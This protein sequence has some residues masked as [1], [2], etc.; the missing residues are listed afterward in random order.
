MRAIVKVP[1]GK[2][3]SVVALLRPS[4]GYRRYGERQILRR[5]GQMGSNKRLRCFFPCPGPRWGLI[6]APQFGIKPF[7][8]FGR[9]QADMIIGV[10]GFFASGKDTVADFL[11]SQYGFGHLSLSDMIRDRL[12][13]A[14]DPITIERLTEM[15]NRIRREEGPGALGR[16]ALSRMRPERRYVV[17]S[18]RHPDEL[19]TLRERPPCLMLFVD[20]PIAVRYAR[21]VRRGRGDDAMSFEQF[22]QAEQRQMTT[23]DSNAQNLA[24]C[25]ALADH[26]VINDQDLEV[27]YHQVRALL[28]NFYPDAVGGS[29]ERD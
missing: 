25:K 26:V 24:A 16:I 11:M 4:S 23:Q 18:I 20:A 17:T 9:E 7:F 14:G 8:S 19:A 3:D 15:G 21:S 2:A 29:K 12:S 10:T 5:S 6:M 13:A 28:A 27:L 22:V 1:P